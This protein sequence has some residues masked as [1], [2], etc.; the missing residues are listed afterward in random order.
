[1]WYKA[2]QGTFLASQEAERMMELIAEINHILD[3]KEKRFKLERH[4]A[5]DIQESKECPFGQRSSYA[6]IL[7]ASF[8][9]MVFTNFPIS[10]GFTR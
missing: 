1:M 6:L 3:E 4:G 9:S 8:C 2:A 5:T 10:A 7:A